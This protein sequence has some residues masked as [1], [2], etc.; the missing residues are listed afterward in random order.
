VEKLAGPHAAFHHRA[1]L[2][3]RA[4][5]LWVSC[6]RQVTA[7][8]TGMGAIPIASNHQSE[9][10]AL[11]TVRAPYWW[12]CRF[13]TTRFC[14]IFWA[15]A[16]INLG[17]EEKYSTESLPGCANLRQCSR[18]DCKPTSP[19]RDHVNEPGGVLSCSLGNCLPMPWRKSKPAIGSAKSSRLR[20]GRR[21]CRHTAV[22]DH[23]GDIPKVEDWW[24]TRGRGIA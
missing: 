21:S 11:Y 17:L 13:H 12:R 7:V 8:A 15:P 20:K 4:L 18:S 9:F 24:K 22:L 14:H 2:Q 23:N 6:H 1:A 3:A 19:T 16:I 5:E 10:P